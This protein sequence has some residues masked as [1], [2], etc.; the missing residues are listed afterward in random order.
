MATNPMPPV[1]S[2]LRR[3]PLRLLHIGI[4][5]LI[6]L[7]LTTNAAFILNLHKTTLLNEE[8][9]LSTISL[10]L[11][12][13]ANRSFESVDLVI[14]SVADGIAVKGVTDPASFDRIMAGSDIRLLLQAQ[15]SGTPQLDAVLVL[16]SEGRLINSSRTGS[17]PIVD[18]SDR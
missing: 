7:L 13:Q 18:N 10:F 2:K 1:T 16:N 11:A 8:D 5:V 14:R 4:S 9:R 6:L 17:I 12:E 15:I 3:S